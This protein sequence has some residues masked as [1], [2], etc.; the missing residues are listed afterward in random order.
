MHLLFFVKMLL[1]SYFPYLRMLFC[2]LAVIQQQNEQRCG[3]ELENYKRG[4]R[5]GAIMPDSSLP[6]YSDEALDEQKHAARLAD[7]KVALAVQVY[8][9]V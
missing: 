7:E 5:S 4:V 6:K 3:Q 1:V 9:L 2:L 8:D